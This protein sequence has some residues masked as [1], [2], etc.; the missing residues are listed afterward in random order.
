MG[1]N[2]YNGITIVMYIT[3]MLLL[4][5]SVLH[6][7]V[8]VNGLLFHIIYPRSIIMKYVDIVCNIVLSIYLAYVMNVYGGSYKVG[9]FNVLVM[10]CGITFYMNQISTKSI[11]VHSVC[12]QGF[13]VLASFLVLLECCPCYYYGLIGECMS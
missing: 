10:L 4:Y 11:L 8:L 3:P 2:I 12:V 6:F 1:G 9:L 5:R 7:V 13:L